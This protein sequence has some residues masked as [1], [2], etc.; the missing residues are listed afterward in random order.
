MYYLACAL[1]EA[2]MGLAGVAVT[3]PKKKFVWATSLEDALAGLCVCALISMAARHKHKYAVAAGSSGLGCCYAVAWAPGREL[4]A[5]GSIDGSIVLWRR[6]EPEEG[7]GG[8]A[9]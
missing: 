8:D 4:L 5:S 6:P 2:G 7:G 1:L 3:A 9:G